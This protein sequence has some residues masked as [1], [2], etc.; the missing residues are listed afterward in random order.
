[1]R[2][3]NDLSFYL[4]DNSGAGSVINHSL[5][6]MSVAVFHSSNRFRFWLQNIFHGSMSLAQLFLCRPVV[7]EGL[8]PGSMPPYTPVPGLLLCGAGAHPG[9]GVMGAPGVLAARAAISM[10]RRS[11]DAIRQGRQMI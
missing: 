3:D 10:A 7:S 8:A 6:A 1:M 2:T 4:G 11:A 9:G 5:R